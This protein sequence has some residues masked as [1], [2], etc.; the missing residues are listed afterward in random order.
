MNLIFG[1]IYILSI[2]TV[3]EEGSQQTGTRSPS[4]KTPR[5]P[6]I[7]LPVYQDI[8]GIQI[9][10]SGFLF[11]RSYGQKYLVIWFL[12]IQPNGPVSNFASSFNFNRITAC[13]VMH[14]IAMTH[15]FL[16]SILHMQVQRLGDQATGF[17]MHYW[18][19]KDK[20]PKATVIR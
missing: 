12:F 10:S 18:T 17:T 3:K 9:W 5:Q 11:I 4:C 8:L 1:P 13:S 19:A 6:T 7:Y 14:L 15:H 16:F 2:S 20:K